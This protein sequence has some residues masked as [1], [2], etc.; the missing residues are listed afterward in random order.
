MSQCYEKHIKKNQIT[1]GRKILLKKLGCSLFSRNKKI[2]NNYF[3]QP[4]KLFYVLY[5]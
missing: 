5:F 3:W 4:E 1:N 2:K